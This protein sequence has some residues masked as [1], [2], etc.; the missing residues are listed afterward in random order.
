MSR[1]VINREYLS[2]TSLATRRSDEWGPDLTLVTLPSSHVGRMKAH[3][4]FYNL[5]KRQA[6]MLGRSPDRE[7]G[8]WG[9]SGFVAEESVLD[10]PELGLAGLLCLGGID[11]LREA[12]GFD[13]LEVGVDRVTTPDLPNSF[14]GVSG[15]G[16]WHFNVI[17]PPGSADL[18][19]DGRIQLEG[20]AFYETA[21]DSGRQLIRCHGRKSL[22]VWVSN[23][24]VA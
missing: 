18:F 10:K 5:S 20:V 2:P 23:M 15:G 19:W 13:Y 1:F 17:R 21:V 7:G 6:E 16:L 24:S 9:V 12:E 11:F 8:F 4:S 14:G 3:K 22:Y